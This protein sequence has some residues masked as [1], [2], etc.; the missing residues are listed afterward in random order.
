VEATVYT[1][2]GSLAVS[3]TFLPA[4]HYQMETE[5]TDIRKKGD[6]FCCTFRFHGR[7]HYFT[8]GDESEAYAKASKSMKLWT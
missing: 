5:L 7:R 8:V 4:R 1:S 3:A 6:A 2:N